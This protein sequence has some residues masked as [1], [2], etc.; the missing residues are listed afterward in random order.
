MRLLGANHKSRQGRTTVVLSARV[1]RLG[2]AIALMDVEAS[3]RCFL[4]YPSS[5]GDVLRSYF[6]SP[7]NKSGERGAGWGNVKMALRL[8]W[9]KRNEEHSR[10]GSDAIPSSSDIVN[11][12]RTEIRNL[13]TG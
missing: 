2:G 8:S 7:Q 5:C 11:L 9:T 6:F 1:V 4:M 13:Y 10:S 12:G 3:N